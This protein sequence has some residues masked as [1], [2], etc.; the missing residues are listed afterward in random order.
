MASNLIAGID[1]LRHQAGM[2][3]LTQ[4]L[5]LYLESATSSWPRCN[6]EA[7]INAF[8]QETGEALND[9]IGELLKDLGE[10]QPNW[11]EHSLQ[12]ATKWAEVEILRQHPHL[13]R[14]ATANLGW[15]FSYWHK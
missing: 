4:A 6:P 14:E 7:V 1:L 3:Q 11:Q 13:D 8:G 9:E 10:L 15:A 12:S 2:S 5:S